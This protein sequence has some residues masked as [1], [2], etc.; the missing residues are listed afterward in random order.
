MVTAHTFG[1]IDGVDRKQGLVS[2][3]SH[4]LIIQDSQSQLSINSSSRED[5]PSGTG[6]KT[7]RISGI[8][9]D[10]KRK[11][12]I[13]QL[14]GQE[15]TLT[16]QEYIAIDVAEV[17]R[18]GE[19][20]KNLGDIYISGPGQTLGIIEGSANKVFFSHVIVPDGTEGGLDSWYCF[21]G[22]NNQDSP[23]QYKLIKV[24]RNGIEQLLQQVTTYPQAG[25]F[26]HEFKT[27][28]PITKAII[29]IKGQSDGDGVDMRAGL[30]LTFN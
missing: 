1:K 29:C 26:H 21:N 22:P 25:K 18:A 10:W 7:I 5:A 23:I 20:K 11:G 6:A 13:I 8:G 14:T 17:V 4:P 24:A 28:L 9:S 27:A 16:K 19:E 15:P 30:E 12:E 3:S 2:V